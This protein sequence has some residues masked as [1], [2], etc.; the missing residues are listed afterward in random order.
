M[1]ETEVEAFD[2]GDDLDCDEV[3]HL[4]HLTHDE[5]FPP[6]PTVQKAVQE[7]WSRPSTAQNG[8]ALSEVEEISLSASNV[9]KF[10]SPAD[11]L[12]NS[13]RRRVSGSPGYPDDPPWSPASSVAPP[14]PTLLDDGTIIQ[15]S[16][17]SAPATPAGMSLQPLD[18]V[19]PTD[20]DDKAKTGKENCAVM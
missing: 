20:D 10:S 5:N 17:P 13:F 6:K 11:K 16:D 8:A 1:T 2:L 3:G 14:I 15:V 18:G 9:E 4:P 7:S 12:H 19:T